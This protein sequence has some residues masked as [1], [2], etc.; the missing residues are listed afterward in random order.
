M[1]AGFGPGLCSVSTEAAAETEQSRGSRKKKSVMLFASRIFF[2]FSRP[3]PSSMFEALERQWMVAL[4]TM[5][6]KEARAHST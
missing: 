3:D 4:A 6:C 5:Q 1:L 2:L